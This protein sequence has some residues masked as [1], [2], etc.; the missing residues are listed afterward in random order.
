MLFRIPYL[1]KSTTSNNVQ[2]TLPFT[3]LSIEIIRLLRLSARED[4]FPFNS[5]RTPQSIRYLVLL[6]KIKRGQSNG[7]VQVASLPA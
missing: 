1:P 7:V 5:N 2:V 6:L 3:F 4:Q